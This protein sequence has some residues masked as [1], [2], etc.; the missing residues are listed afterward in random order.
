[1]HYKMRQRLVS[2]GDDS[3]IETDSGQRAYKV[4]G[5][6]PRLRKALVLGDPHG[7]ELAKI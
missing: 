3:W 1:M 4:N 6:V 2:I 5:K 7:H